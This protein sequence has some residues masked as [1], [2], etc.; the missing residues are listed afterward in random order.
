MPL[1]SIQPH[2]I[3]LTATSINV[4]IYEFQFGSRIVL[5]VSF[6]DTASVFLLYKFVEISGEAY[7]QM[8]TSQNSDTYIREYIQTALG[9]T[10][11]IEPV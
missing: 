1:T 9:M 2:D 3:T 5:K 11:Q 7:T 4:E 8:T 6:F 10:I